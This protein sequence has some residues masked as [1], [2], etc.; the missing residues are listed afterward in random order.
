MA[1]PFDMQVGAARVRDVPLSSV[2]ALLLTSNFLHPSTSA[3][4]Y[5]LKV[6]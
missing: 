5:H 1:T 6:K 3:I 4:A 2:G